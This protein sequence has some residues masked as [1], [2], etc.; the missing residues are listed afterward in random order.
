MNYSFRDFQ[1]IKYNF[2]V[3]FIRHNSCT[4]YWSILKLHR[5]WNFQ[6]ENESTYKITSHNFI[7][8]DNL[9]KKS[10]MS[11]DACSTSDAG[12]RCHILLTGNGFCVPSTCNAEKK[13]PTVG[14]PM[15]GAISGRC[16]DDGKCDYS[17]AMMMAWVAMTNDC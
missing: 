11:D 12:W 15:S 4:S 7:C 2:F 14:T 6:L 5:M 13:C 16:A 17:P 1:Y 3:C 9:A 10:C 8:L